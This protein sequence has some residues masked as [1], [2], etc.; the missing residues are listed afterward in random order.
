M[1]TQRQATAAPA[2]NRAK[3]GS[4]RFPKGKSGN[5][6]GRKPGSLNKRTLVLEHMTDDDR[7]ALVAKV[8]GQAKRG[9]R[10]SQKMILDRIEPPRKGRAA[11]F[12]LPPIASISDVI[13]ALAAVTAAMAAGQVSP[14]E[15]VEIASVIEL[16]RRAVE[17]LDL[18][19]RLNA[20]EERFK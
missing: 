5:P 4:G 3:T 6:A 17:N 7:A 15:A 9:C 1:V 2:K 19:T 16:Q 11:R 14:A 10:P 8:I 12:A 20:L 18:E 13:T